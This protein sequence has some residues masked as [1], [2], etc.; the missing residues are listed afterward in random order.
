MKSPFTFDLFPDCIT[1]SVRW[2]IQDQACF[3][4]FTVFLFALEVSQLV[5]VFGVGIYG[6]QARTE[7]QFLE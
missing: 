4:V 5:C 7:A 3:A 2:E 1:A 6:W